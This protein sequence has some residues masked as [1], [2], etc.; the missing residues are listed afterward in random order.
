MG[1]QLKSKEINGCL[2]SVPW[3]FP[4]SLVFIVMLW[5]RISLMPLFW[6]GIALLLIVF[7]QPM[8]QRLL[9]V[10]LYA[11]PY[12][13]IKLFGMVPL[14]EC[15]LLEVPI[16]R[17]WS[18][19][20][21]KKGNVLPDLVEMSSGK[22]FGLSL[23]KKKKKKRSKFWTVFFKKICL[24]HQCDAHEIRDGAKNSYG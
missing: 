16:I 19:W 13:R 10:S 8:R 9:K 15:F 4:L 24:K 22:S 5:C 7:F 20:E 12:L 2:I 21:D 6:D 1:I 3:V 14:M 11:L 23:Q 18:W 17:G